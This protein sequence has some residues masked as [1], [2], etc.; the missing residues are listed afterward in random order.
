MA[1]ALDVPLRPGLDTFLYAVP[2]FVLVAIGMF[3]LDGLLARPKHRPKRR[4]TQAGMD[5]DGLPVLCDPDG[6]N[7]SP[8]R[9]AKERNEPP[10]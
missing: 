2:V 1:V 10:A 6:R 5:K 4:R 8:R 7:F 9:G 3:R